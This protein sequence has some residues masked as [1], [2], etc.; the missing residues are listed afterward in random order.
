MTRLF[1]NI[2]EDE[3]EEIILKFTNFAEALEILI[4][5]EPSE[6]ELQKAFDIGVDSIFED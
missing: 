2:T 4:G 5:H 6:K 1:D 3:E